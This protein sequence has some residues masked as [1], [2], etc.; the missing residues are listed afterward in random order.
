MYD[1]L[2]LLPFLSFIF[3]VIIIFMR[4]QRVVVRIKSEAYEK[5]QVHIRCFIIIN[6]V[7]I[8]RHSLVL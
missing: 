6:I 5:Y 7:A 8:V 2:N 3:L 1:K 4:Y